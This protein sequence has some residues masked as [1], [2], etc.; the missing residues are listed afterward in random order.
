MFAAGPLATVSTRRRRTARLAYRPSI[1]PMTYPNA[2]SKPAASPTILLIGGSDSSGGAG[3]QADLRV[4]SSYQLAG[5]CVVTAATA[6]NT[7]TLVAVQPLSAKQVLTQLDAVL[8]DLTIH[9]VKVGMLASPAIVRAVAGRLRQLRVPIVLDPV[10]TASVG[11]ALL[12][13]AARQLMLDHLL[14]LATVFTP[15]LP[16]VGTLLGLPVSSL[17]QRRTALRCLT[18]LGGHWVLIKGGHGTGKRLLDLFGT[19]SQTF[20]LTATRLPIAT[21]GTGCTYASAIAAELALGSTPQHAIACGH[22]YLQAALRQ[23]LIL[24]KP[25]VYCPGFPV[26]INAESRHWRGL[27]A[28]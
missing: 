3:L 12:A 28:V 2:I 19:R 16:E 27:N 18:D 9:A 11:G 26:A 10:L 14:P 21:H 1:R 23:P 15:N 13:P 17:S 24:G 6:Q 7:G 25:A 20:Q 4:L 5:A 8:D 22:A